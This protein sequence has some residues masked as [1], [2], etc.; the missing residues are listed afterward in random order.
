MIGFLK[1]VSVSRF[2][3]HSLHSCFEGRDDVG[4]YFSEVVIFVRI[5]DEIVQF[6]RRFEMEI[7]LKGDNQLPFR[8]APTVLPHPGAFRDVKLTFVGS[9]VPPYQRHQAPAIE[10]DHRLDS[11][12]FK[13]G[14]HK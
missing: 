1:P 11:R 10:R 3:I 14:W 7:R 5:L 9:D 4:I 6:D 2:A 13:D 8:R 12:Q